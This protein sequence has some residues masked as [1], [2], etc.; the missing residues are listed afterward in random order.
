[1]HIVVP[2]LVVFAMAAAIWLLRSRTVSIA[3]PAT[4][5]TRFAYLSAGKL[6]LHEGAGT[7]REVSSAFALEAANRVEQARERRSW[8]EGTSFNIGA[9]GR[10]RSFDPEASRHRMTAVAAAPNNQLL[11]ALS[12]ASIGGIFRYDLQQGSEHRLL[13]QQHLQVSSLLVSPDGEQIAASIQHPDGTTSIAL[14]DAD[15]GRL[16]MVTGGDSQDTAP[17]FVH[18]F[19]KRL[20]FQSA[21]VARNEAGYVVALGPSSVQLLNL[22]NG[23][24]SPVVESL[25]FDYLSPRV[26]PNGDL[27]FI[28]RPYL[29][30]QYQPKNA[31]LDVVL[32]PFRLARAVFH[33]LNFF[34]LTYSRKPLTTATGSPIKADLQH[35]MLQGRHIDAEKALRKFRGQDAAPS[36]VPADWELVRRTPAGVESVVAQSAAS[37]DISASGDII[38]SN[39]FALFVINS[40]TGASPQLVRAE[41]VV[42]TVAIFNAR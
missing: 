17:C 6:L 36:L 14:T 24:V 27:F 40:K 16:R 37:F 25:G 11:Y 30:S 28:R 31:F 34:S 20:L 18:N 35:I 41:E 1:M 33:Y 12:D 4:T 21:G 3:K 38:Y 23:S 26:H 2:L 13:I 39:G 7:T 5:A 29:A 22:E 8:R 10:Y 32:F 9:G 19:P 42:G 15:A